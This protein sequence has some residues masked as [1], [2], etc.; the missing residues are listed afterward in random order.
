MG[1]HRRTQSLALSLLYVLPLLAI[2]ELWLV[3]ER[4]RVVN[5]AG[6]MARL[7]LEYLARIIENFGGPA[8]FTAS[9]LLN[10]AVIAAFIYVY[11]RTD[12]EEGS[13]LSPLL[14]MAIESAIYGVFLGHIVV[15]IMDLVPRLPSSQLAMSPQVPESVT[16]ILLSVGAGVYEELVFRL[17]LVGGLVYIG[18]LV[19]QK[20]DFF[21]ACLLVLGAAL[22]FAALQQLTVPE[23]TRSWQAFVRGFLYTSPVLAIMASAVLLLYCALV[24]G[25]GKLKLDSAWAIAATSILIGSLL[26]A[27][28]HHIGPLGEPLEARVFGFRFLAGLFLSIIY[29]TRGLAVA[30]YTHVVYDIL[31]VLSA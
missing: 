31:V 6:V 29:W 26:F 7:P 11:L 27:L 15:F 20:K 8:F 1:Y 14:P 16:P 18:Q 17:L 28:F 30:V 3:M 24:W 13:Q 21:W 9:L 19:F 10:L 25:L 2:Y 4:P 12:S 23:C 5:A 22:G